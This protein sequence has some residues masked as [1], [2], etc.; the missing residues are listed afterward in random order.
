MAWYDAKCNIEI[1]ESHWINAGGM[2]LISN[3]MINKVNKR[4]IIFEKHD[5]CEY[6]VGVP[7]FRL[8]VNFLIFCF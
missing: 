5:S 1:L 4:P 7:R 3:N 6:S 8:S 2:A